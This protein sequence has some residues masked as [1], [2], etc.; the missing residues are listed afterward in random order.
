MLLFGTPLHLLS[1]LLQP[2]AQL[3]QP[4]RVMPNQTV[5]L[6]H[7]VRQFSGIDV[8][9]PGTEHLVDRPY[10]SVRHSH[11]GPLMPQTRCQTLIQLLHQRVLLARGGPGT[12]Q[13][14]IAQV[15]IA[16]RGA[17]TLPFAGALIVART[18]SGPGTQRL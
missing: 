16:F 8:P 13:Q 9:T 12:F 15:R 3:A 5:H 14:S 7:T 10:Q 2:A 17:R 11:N 6:G 1:S 18:Y 4:A